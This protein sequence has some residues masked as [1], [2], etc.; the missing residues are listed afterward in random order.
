MLRFII[1]IVAMLSLLIAAIPHA[2]GQSIPRPEGF[3]NKLI[4]IIVPYGPGGAADLL[5]R[6]V[7]ER[8]SNYWGQPVIVENR[9]G[10]NGSIGIEQVIRSAPD[11]YTMGCI[12]V[13][14]L[15]VNP[16]LYSN[17]R[18]DVFTDLSPVSLIAQVQNVLVVGPS[19]EVQNIRQLIGVAKS[20]P[21]SLTYSSPGAGS[22]AHIAGEMF[23]S[24]MGVSTLHIPYNG[25]GAAI[26]DVLGGSVSMMFAQMQA[27]LPLVNSG[28]LKALAVAS[29]TRS[30]YLPNV[31]TILEQTGVQ[32]FDTVAWSAFMAPAGTPADVRSFIASE[33][34]RALKVPDVQERLR[35]QGAEP[36]GSTPEELAR[37][38][39]TE[40][41][42]YGEII[43][44]AGI[45]LE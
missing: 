9:P 20:K 35:A 16:H 8:L 10:G 45:R 19:L 13:S 25:V 44:K 17:L 36:V 23:N 39:K 24:L 3:P 40:H 37:I 15:V 26:K 1:R 7:G 28:K 30:T 29:P 5:A 34:G 18:F 11:G 21:G 32:G 42:R 14:N 27:A 38:M 31:P 33:V 22:Q 12:A 2:W 41:A 6:I 4:R 43:R